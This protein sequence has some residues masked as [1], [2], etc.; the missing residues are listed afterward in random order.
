[1]KKN[2]LIALVVAFFFTGCMKEKT[3][4]IVGNFNKVL[5]E[6]QSKDDS[7]GSIVLEFPANPY[8]E[9]GKKHNDLL[10][11]FFKEV[12]EKVEPSLYL[13]TFFEMSGVQWQEKPEYYVD[14]MKKISTELYD[15]EGY[16]PALVNENK[17]FSTFE[18][19]ILNAYF[20]KMFCL[21][22]AEEKVEL[23]KKAEEFILHEKEI[24]KEERR[25]ILTSF[26]IFRY[27][28]SFW[29]PFL[30]KEEPAMRSI[31]STL[32]AIGY[33]LAR[34][35]DVCPNCQDGKDLYAYAAGYSFSVGIALGVW[36]Y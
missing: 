25:R 1:M 16:N 27:S 26:A 36:C 11:R 14:L 13:E 28:S 33:W 19:E 35:T 6:Y 23:S 5:N 10:D 21:E 30:I 2:V 8:D 31:C 29:A 34:N 15:K 3:N 20:T 32:D 17:Y 22:K 7:K 4:N 18:K 24:S 12:Y 9:Q